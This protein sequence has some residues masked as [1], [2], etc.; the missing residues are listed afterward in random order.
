MVAVQSRSSCRTTWS[1]QKTFQFTFSRA[2]S[3]D[4][5]LT[6]WNEYS[7]LNPT[8]NILI[9]IEHLDTVGVENDPS[10]PS[11]EILIRIVQRLLFPQPLYTR[12]ADFLRLLTMVEFWRLRAMSIIS[13]A[14]VYQEYYK[15]PMD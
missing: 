3:M 12:I 14:L 1:K 10:P 9:L 7:V 8:R 2:L 15:E 13:N 11:L 5:M 6:T 4:A